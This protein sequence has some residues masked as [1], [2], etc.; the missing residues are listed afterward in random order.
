MTIYNMY[1]FNRAGQCI[2][3]KLNLKPRSFQILAKMTIYNM[4]IFNRAGQCI[5][6]KEWNR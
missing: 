4:Y 1:I 2:Y 6:Y 3:Y 5:Y